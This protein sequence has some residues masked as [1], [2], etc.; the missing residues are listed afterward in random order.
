MNILLAF[1]TF[2]LYGAA[3]LGL[4]RRLLNGPDAFPGR[5][6]CLL[7][8]ALALALH[9]GLLAYSLMPGQASRLG[10]FEASSLVAWL[11]SALLLATATRRPVESLG[12]LILPLSGVAVLLDAIFGPVASTAPPMP[13]GLAAHVISSIVA[14]SI[15]ALAAFQAVLLAVQEHRLHHKHPGGFVRLLPPMQTME[16]LLFQMLRLGFLGLTLALITGF[17]FLED[18][19]AQHLVHK[20]VLSIIAWC[21]FATLLYGR[22]RFG[23]RGKTAIRWTLAGFIVLM[24]SYFGSKFVLEVVLQRF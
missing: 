17:L 2:C 23:W 4:L 5:R 21:V 7:F 20:T 11:I 14:Y 24:L 12:I 3:G 18:M 10:F 6:L 8:G 9:F 13:P 1:I 16:H 22:W 19:F 15:L